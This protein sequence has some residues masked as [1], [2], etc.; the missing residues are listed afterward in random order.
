MILQ[1]IF[2]NK[3]FQF[4]LRFALTANNDTKFRNVPSQVM[5][6]LNESFVAFARNQASD[7]AKERNMMVDTKISRGPVSF[8]PMFQFWR[9]QSTINDMCF[10][11]NNSALDADVADS[12][13]DA[14]DCIEHPVV[15]HCGSDW[16]G[17]VFHSDTFNTELPKHC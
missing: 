15:P 10:T 12:I 3:L 6:C 17:G 8:D 4:R 5:S 16:E 2:T 13:R 7:R 14:N 11:F 9:F 1:L